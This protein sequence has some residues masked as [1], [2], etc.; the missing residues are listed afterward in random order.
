MIRV[1]GS[2]S[3]NRGG[4]G[5]VNMLEGSLWTQIL[6]YALPAMATGGLQLLF[7]AADLVVVGRFCGSLSVAA[8]GATG[9]LVNLIVNLFIG[10][11]V[12]AGVVV[13][14]SLGAGDDRA[15][16]DAVHTAVPT[17]LISGLL[18]AG[19]GFMFAR[20]M[21]ALMGTPEDVIDLSALYMRIYF[22]GM[23]VIIL[24]N[25]GGSI[26]RAK[27]DTRHP[28][29]FL[30]IAG[31]VNVVLNVIFV[32]VFHLDVAG[33]ALATTL[34]QAI[35]ATLILILLSKDDGPCRLEF[36]KLKI[37]KRYLLEMIRIGLPAGLQGSMFSISNVM[38][39]SSMNSFGSVVVA[40]NAAG[41]NI[42]S[43]VWVF[44][45]SYHQ[46]AVNFVGQNYGAKRYDRIYKIKNI[47]IIYV[48]VTGIL[49]GGG[50][51]L[52][53]RQ[54]LGIYITDNPQAIEYGVIRMTIIC[55]PYALNGLHDV[56]TGII[57]GLGK[58]VPP[59]I[60]SV[61]CICG[62][63]LFWIFTFFRLPQ[64]HSVE[65]LYITYP[66]TWIINFLTL[67]VYY[68]KLARKLKNGEDL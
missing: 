53:K 22:L 39:Q 59:M 62:L 16:S 23:P 4:A 31:V 6:R 63:R 21:L 7:N 57:R 46:A 29:I 35:S 9:A 51:F 40:G 1:K 60:I 19:I 3:A 56:M 12:G 32:V 15:V 2:I 43:F 28:L 52:F 33:V 14:Q 25:Y 54:L 34:S 26:L 36:R 66:V 20:P 42:D 10:L 45:N 18:L 68:R 58:S 49:F 38:I 27:G 67:E 5:A 55:L 30:A 47:S 64:F 24:Y 61:I 48:I 17:A 11:S 44:M 37:H 50:L 41:A 13:A 65:W 8:V